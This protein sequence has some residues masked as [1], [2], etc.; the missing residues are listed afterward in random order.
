[1]KVHTL[2]LGAVRS[3]G[4]CVQGKI[5]SLFYVKEAEYLLSGDR[6]QKDQVGLPPY[7]HLVEEFLTAFVLI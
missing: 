6:F 2:E 4:N 5:G 3:R 7:S 1:M